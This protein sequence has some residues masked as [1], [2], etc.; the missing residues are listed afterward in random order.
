MK[1]LF[2]FYLVTIFIPIPIL[3][4]FA[5]NEMNDLFVI[6]LLVYALLYRPIFD[7]LRLKGKGKAE[8]NN[9]WKFFIPFWSL[10]WFKSLYLNK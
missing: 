6:S 10:K 3:I 1:N 8:N 5:L 4:W 9:M 2:I 7:Y